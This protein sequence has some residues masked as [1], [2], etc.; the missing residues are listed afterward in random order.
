M[1][2][3]SHSILHPASRHQHR[4]PR[5]QLETVSVIQAPLKT[6]TGREA[7]ATVGKCVLL[8]SPSEF[9]AERAKHCDR[10][11]EELLVF[12]RWCRTPGAPCDPNMNMT[13]LTPHPGWA[14]EETSAEM[15]LVTWFLEADGHGSHW[16]RGLP[17]QLTHLL[18]LFSS[19]SP[20]PRTCLPGEGEVQTKRIL[21]GTVHHWLGGTSAVLGLGFTQQITFPT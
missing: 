3:K 14:E 13:A 19:K 15:V 8:G 10:R 11:E 17:H 12:Q 20:H 2:A 1:L 6:F 4:R 18:F 9:R 7:A 5:H 16:G 21:Q